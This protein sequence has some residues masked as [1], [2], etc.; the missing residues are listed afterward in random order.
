MEDRERLIEYVRSE[1]NR[2]PA[3]PRVVD[4]PVFILRRYTSSFGLQMVGAAL[5]V[6]AITL[7]VVIRD[8]FPTAFSVVLFLVVVVAAGFCLV[9]PMI[10]G[11]IFVRALRFGALAE[12]ELVAINHSGKTPTGDVV[13]RG[14][15]GQLRKRFVSR[16]PWFQSA[17]IGSRVEVLVDYRHPRILMVLGPTSSTTSVANAS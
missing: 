13:V 1:A 8:G 12:G 16:A 10:L 15:S 7:S 17:Q 9:A 14:A 4:A 11:W 6:L 2:H 5:V 3:A